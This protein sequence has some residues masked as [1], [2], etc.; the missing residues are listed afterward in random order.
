M[1]VQSRSALT[2]FHD[3]IR[4]SGGW[5]VDDPQDIIARWQVLAPDLM[6]KLS[7]SQSTWLGHRPVS[8]LGRPF[9]GATAQRIRQLCLASAGS[10]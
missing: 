7:A 5:G 3:H 6:V 1:D 2:V 4:I 9:I 10:Q 8:P